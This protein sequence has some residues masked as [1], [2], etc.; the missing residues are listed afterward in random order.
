MKSTFILSVFLLS[1]FFANAQT[2]SFALKKQLKDDIATRHSSQMVSYNGKL[3]FF[4]GYNQGQISSQVNDFWEYTPT[5]KVFRRLELPNSSNPI[6]SNITHVIG[7]KMY[8][9]F[10]SSI[11]ANGTVSNWMEYDFITNV[12]TYKASFPGVVTGGIGNNG[13]FVIN[14]TI[15]VLNGSGTSNFYSYN[16][17][18]NTWSQ[19]A[20]FPGTARTGCFNFSINGKG[21]IGGGFA[22]TCGAN[23]C[24]QPDFY[25]YNP[26]TNV[27]VAK[28]ALSFN[29]SQGI[30]V[31][32]NGKVYVGTGVINGGVNPN[33]TTNIWKEYNSATDTWTNKANA[34]LVHKATAAVVGTDVF[35]FSGQTYSS[36]INECNNA[37]NRYNTLTDTWSID[38]L[39]AGGNR[40]YGNTF[41]NNNKIY[42]VG[43]ADGRTYNDTWEYDIPTD[44]W[45]RKADMPTSFSHRAQV[46][47]G[48]KL[49]VVGGY[50]TNASSSSNYTNEFLEYDIASNTWA[51]KT[52]FPGGALRLMSAFT[53]NNEIYAGL[54]WNGVTT[55]LQNYKGLY[56]YNLSNN[57]WQA[58]AS[59]PRVGS[60]ET[61]GT[62]VIGDT[63][64][65]MFQDGNVWAYNRIANSWS[66]K[67]TVFE[68]NFANYM[69]EAA[70]SM[71]GSGFVIDNNNVNPSLSNLKKYN[72]STN[73]WE[74]VKRNL[75][76]KRRDVYNAVVVND[77]TFYL[78]LGLYYQT[79]PGKY[80][81]IN[82]WHKFSFKADIATKVGDVAASAMD[83]RN[84][85]TYT[86]YDSLG[87]LLLGAIGGSV[88]ITSNISGRSADTLLPYREKLAPL[89]TNGTS[90]NIMFLN[91]NFLMVQDGFS[92]GVKIRLF[93]TNRE[94]TKF[95]NSFNAK[96]GTS[97]TENNISIFN[98]NNNNNPANND[99]DPLNNNTGIPTNYVVSSIVP[100][101]TGKYFEITVPAGGLILGELYAILST[102]NVALPLS[103]LNFAASLNNTVVQT[104][105]QTASEVNFS[106]FN[107]E[108]SLDGRDFKNI[109]KVDAFS[110]TGITTKKYQYDDQNATSLGTNKLYYR[111]QIVDKDGS[112]TYSPIAIIN[113]S[114][115][116]SITVSPN[117]ASEYI[118]VS[119]S[120]SLQTIQL[121]DL[122]G[123][124]VKTVNAN[125][126]SSTSISIASLAKGQYQI[127][128][129]DTK[130]NMETKK[131]VKQ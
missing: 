99:L 112:S 19:K 128:V 60:G 97:Y 56:K 58:L 113:L 119:G 73:T 46:K 75:N 87:G 120:T 42:V 127:K 102:T 86:V 33:Y 78:G 43:G 77:S 61:S 3:Y 45:T 39:T 7:S 36:T 81:T 74:Y 11:P 28:S 101:G 15:Y 108:R 31:V 116:N 40:V 104:Q 105:W 49:Y 123:R 48:N 57:T 63:A 37:I 131:I 27:W 95:V 107:I 98:F 114:S 20:N 29:T 12:W 69:H 83:L 22:G 94:I 4:G 30:S 2:E 92:A 103:I 72:P 44:A 121:Y 124:L 17:V 54:G 13:S 55:G 10:N 8:V 118:T 53:I 89:A 111:L 51:T 80:G 35:I 34:P 41:Y 66:Q 82:D 38:T 68:F 117:P 88:S 71:A 79:P 62:F 115:K 129:T 125:G 91:K 14:D 6:T 93:F 52:A 24:S 122:M 26:T 9:G 126:S 96:Y 5:T 47:I 25:E 106:H 18:T 59:C 16:I 110:G 70:F 32:A 85:E 90:N 100:Y 65:I 76:I 130:G 1:F 23:L 84:N 64:Y 21:Y 67:A 50:N 109:G